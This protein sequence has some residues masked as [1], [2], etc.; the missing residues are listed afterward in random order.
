MEAEVLLETL[1]M[2]VELKAVEMNLRMEGWSKMM[3][4][5]NL[6]VFFSVD[7]SSDY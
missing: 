6:E 7:V 4:L 3:D 2:V 5:V 1:Q